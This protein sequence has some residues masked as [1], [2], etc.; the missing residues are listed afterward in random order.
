MNIRQLSKNFVSSNDDGDRDAVANYFHEDIVFCTLDGNEI[1]GAANV[2]KS[3]QEL[4]SGPMG[5]MSFELLNVTADEEAQTSAVYWHA[6]HK[7]ESGDTMFSWFGNDIL[8]WKDGKII[9][10]DTFGK[11]DAPKVVVRGQDI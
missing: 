4:T 7:D 11:C 5:K 3:L 8:T 10:K 6:F 9:R 2:A 1:V